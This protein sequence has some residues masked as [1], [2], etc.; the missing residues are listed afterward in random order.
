MISVIVPVY[1]AEKYIEKC[2]V[3]VLNQTYTD[4]ELLL[5]NDGSTDSSPQICSQWAQK[6]PRIIVISQPNGGVS[7]ARNL[8]LD[9]ARG[10]FIYFIDAD[11]WISP[12]CFEKMMAKMSD[13]VDLIISTYQRPDENGNMI[14]EPDDINPAE[15]IYTNAD[16]MAAAYTKPFYV[17]VVWGKLYRK[18]LWEHVR[19]EHLSYS[20]D[21]YALFEI[22]M[23]VQKFYSLDEPLYY[24]LQRRSSVSFQRKFLHL[25]ELLQTLFFEYKQAVERYPEFLESA[26]KL[27]FSKCHILLKLYCETK[28]KE[29]AFQLIR[30]MKAVYKATQVPYT[31]RIYRILVLPDSLIYLYAKIKCFFKKEDELL[32]I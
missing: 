5:I 20:E 26:A 1:N 24:Y 19:F 7:T 18:T 10:E 4:F 11:D 12:N 28:Q 9:R 8:G 25:E 15:G 21:T 31:D 17:R 22:F 23:L 3:S 6:D 14:F 13:D 16:C 32:E 29:K 2:I 27:F 30:G